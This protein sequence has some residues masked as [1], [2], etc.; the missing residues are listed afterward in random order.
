MCIYCFEGITLNQLYESER[1]NTPFE[2]DGF[3]E[4]FHFQECES[5]AV[6]IQAEKRFNPSFLPALIGNAFC[7]LYSEYLTTGHDKSLYQLLKTEIGTEAI[8]ALF[9]E[10]VEDNILWQGLVDPDIYE[11]EQSWNRFLQD[12]ERASQS[13]QC[14]ETYWTWRSS[15]VETENDGEQDKKPASQAMLGIEFPAVFFA[16]EY[17]AK[18]QPHSE[19]I[20]RIARETLDTIPALSPDDLWLQRRAFGHC[21]RTYGSQFIETGSEKMRVDLIYYHLQKTDYSTEE[22]ERWEKSVMA[23]REYESINATPSNILELIRSLG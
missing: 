19:W 4:I 13:E 8:H 17:L 12:I 18:Y 10:K 6:A 15:G 1:N 9:S 11:D 5:L 16:L 20:K 21:A 3:G 14:L 23:L 2:L 7:R 22:L